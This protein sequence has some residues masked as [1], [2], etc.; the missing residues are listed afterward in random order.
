MYQKCIK[1][2]IIYDTKNMQLGIIMVLCKKGIML[3]K[4]IM[5]NGFIIY[6]FENILKENKL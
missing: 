4:N 1:I 5:K 6:G 3:D 2:C